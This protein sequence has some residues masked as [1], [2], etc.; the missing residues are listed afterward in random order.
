[1]L[2]VGTL[3]GKVTSFD[4]KTGEYIWSHEVSSTPLMKASSMPIVSS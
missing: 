2:L 3:D 4:L 1:M